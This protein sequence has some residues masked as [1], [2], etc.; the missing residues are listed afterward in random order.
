MFGES[1]VARVA[2]FEPAIVVDHAERVAGF[3][4]ALVGRHPVPANRVL[5]RRSQSG[6]GQRVDDIAEQVLRIGVARQR[7]RLEHRDR[8]AGI[9]GIVA[10][11]GA[12]EVGLSR[13]QGTAGQRARQGRH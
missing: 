10:L 13:D 2:F 9:T 7:Q 8:L 4:R 12:V 5:A 11:D 6:L 1:R 3:G